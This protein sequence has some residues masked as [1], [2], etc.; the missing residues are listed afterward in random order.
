MATWV[1][2]DDHRDANGNLDWKSYDAAKVANGETCYQCGGTASLFG[3]GRQ[4]LCGD[5]TRMAADDDDVSHDTLIRCP[6]CR[7]A[8][9]VYETDDYELYSDGEHDVTCPEC[10]HEFEVVTAVSF[11]FT[12]RERDD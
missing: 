9:N 7:H 4:S 2:M 8:W 1:N 11:R 6:K 5:C 3:R 10:E 12:S